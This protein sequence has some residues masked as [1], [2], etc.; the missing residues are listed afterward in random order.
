MFL[1]FKFKDGANLIDF[2]KYFR[3]VQRKVDF[4]DPEKK[5][6]IIGVIHK[7]EVSFQQ[8]T[9][10]RCGNFKKVVVD[11]DIFYDSESKNIAGKIDRAV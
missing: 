7:K 9:V 3:F 11:F 8:I 1:V 6:L 5:G 4:H 2:L 10:H